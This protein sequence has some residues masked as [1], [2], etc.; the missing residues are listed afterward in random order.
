MSTGIPSTVTQSTAVSSLAIS[1]AIEP[2]S[3]YPQ[4]T[5][6]E[7]S[8]KS[9]QANQRLLTV[10]ETI[11]WDKMELLTSWGDAGGEGLFTPQRNNTLNSHASN[12]PFLIFCSY[13]PTIKKAKVK[14][15]AVYN[16]IA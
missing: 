13:Y 15:Q 4:M 5:Q 6:Q 14:T 1:P 7:V 12:V 10:P 3:M 2:H 8:K 16:R 11:T 9:D